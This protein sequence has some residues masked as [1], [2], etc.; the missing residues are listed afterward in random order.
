MII[1]VSYIPF[2]F[3]VFNHLSTVHYILCTRLAGSPETQDKSQGMEQ[4]CVPPV[5]I[6]RLLMVLIQVIRADS[7][8]HTLVSELYKIQALIILASSG[9]GDSLQI[10]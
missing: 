8:N 9:S 10:N 6:S 4:D 5:E 7:I 1:I 3:L 2:G